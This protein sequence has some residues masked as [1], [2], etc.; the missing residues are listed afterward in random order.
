MNR[1][2]GRIALT[3]KTWQKGTALFLIWVMLFSLFGV[4]APPVSAQEG[5]PASGQEET[6]EPL[7][8][9]LPPLPPLPDVHL[10]DMEW[11][12]AESGWKEVQ[13]NKS[14]EGNTLS[15]GG[16]EYSKGIGTHASS[17]IVY[18]IPAGYARFVSVAGVDNEIN[19]F[20]PDKRASMTFR[21]YADE[22]LLAESP[23]LHANGYWYFDVA[24]PEGAQHLNLIVDDMGSNEFDHADW[25]NAG[26]YN[27]VDTEGDPV[28]I[29][30]PTGAVTASVYFNASGQLVYAVKYSG[31]DVIEES[32]LG[33]YYDNVDLG[34]GVKLGEPERA[35]THNETYPWN[36]G[37][38]QAEDRHNL[39]KIPITH[40]KSGIQYTLEIK[41]FDEGIAFRYVMPGEGTHTISGEKTNFK[42]PAG[43]TVWYQQNT[44]NYEGRFTKSPAESV[45]PST[46]IGPP[47]TI[48]LPEGKGYAAI[49]EGNL[50]DYSGMSLLAAG[51]GVFKANFL[52]DNG[53]W[54]QTGTIE[55]PW[56]IVMMN[57]DL[58]GLV[59]NDIVHNTA[60]APSPELANAD[61]IQPGK[62]TWSWLGGGGVTVEN[63]KQYIDFASQLGI[64]SNLVDE[65]WSHWI[66]GNRDC[67]DLLKEVVDYGTERN[68]KT[69]VWKAAPDRYGIPGIYNREA[70]RE[71]FRKLKE[72]GVVG[73]KID[74]IDGE[75]VNQVNFYRDTLEDAAEYKLMINFHGANKPT[76]LSRTYPHEVSREGIYGLENWNP[77][78]E[79]NTTLPFTRFLAGHA[80]Y[81]PMHFTGRLGDTT[82]SHQLA[83]TITFTS[84]QL[85]FAEHP[86]TI[87]K[88]PAV[89]FIKSIPSVWDETIV[90]P[91]SKIGEVSA[92]ARRQG[93]TWYVAVLNNT[94]AR[95]M[96]VNLSFL[97]E[98]MYQASIYGDKPGEQAAYDMAEKS[99]AKQDRFNV[100]LNAGGGFVAKLS[101]MDMKPYGGGF[102]AKQ[103]VYLTV[104]DPGAE[105]RYTLDGS[106]PTQNSPLYKDFIA[107]DESAVI[108]AKIVAGEGAGSE[109]SARFNKRVPKLAITN[110]GSQSFLH[111]GDKVTLKT[112]NIDAD[113]EIRYTLDGSEPDQ[114]AM[115]YTEPFA[116]YESAIVKAR[117]FVE[118]ADTGVAAERNFTVLDKPRLPDVHLSDLN[119]VSAETEW[120]QVQKN[121]SSDGNSL[122]VGGTTYPKGIG[123]HANSKIVYNIPP[124]ARR[125]VAI[126]GVDDEISESMPGKYASMI[127]KVY[128]DDTLLSESPA[129]HKNDYWYFDVDIPYGSQQLTLIVDDD[130]APE[131]DHADWVQAGF[132]TKVA[133]KVEEITVTG[134]DG[135][136]KIATD[137]GTLQM[138]AS[139]MPQN[140]D[141]KSV[142]WSVSDPGKAS[143]DANGLL[144]AK[145][146][147][148]VDVIA[149]ARDGSG[150][151]GRKTITI[152]GQT[153]AVP[154]KEIVVTGKDQATAITKKG[155]TLQMIASVKPEG[156][157]NKAVTWSVSDPSKAWI[158]ANGLL[159]AKANGRV[160]VRA[161]AQ[162]GS[163]VT[164]KTIITISGQ[165]ISFDADA[166]VLDREISVDLSQEGKADWIR[167]G[168]DKTIKSR[169]NIGQPL[170]QFQPF[171]TQ[172]VHQMYDYKGRFTWNDGNPTA[173]GDNERYGIYM[174]D[175]YSG[176]QITVPPGQHETTVKVY[177]G[178]WAS[179]GRI[180]ALFGDSST[181]VYTDHYDNK[182]ENSIHK[183]YTFR[184]NG[185]ES[186][187]SLII[188][189]KVEG[190]Y[191]PSG[192]V[193]L[194]AAVMSNSVSEN[195]P[196]WPEGSVLTAS[197]IT[198]S[199]AVLTWSGADNSTTKY[200]IYQ[201]N[202]WIGT[203]GSDVKSYK[204][205]ELAAGVTYTFRVEAG[206]ASGDWS[207][208][209]PSASVQT[210]PDHPAEVE[211]IKP[212]EVLTSPGKKPDLPDKV[213]A[214][215]ADGRTEELAVEW[216][217]IDPKRYEKPGTF[218]V[219]GTVAGTDKKATANIFVAY[220]QNQFIVAPA[221]NMDKLEPDRTLQA[222]VIVKNNSSLAEN[223]LVIAALY[224]QDQRMVDLS[225]YSKK[226][227]VG[228]TEKL[229]AGF[230]LPNR[231]QGHQVKVF[232]WRGE[233][234]ENSPMKPLSS[235][236]ILK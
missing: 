177:T 152:S 21:V 24:I 25:V 142:A 65:G 100:K 108:R 43:S 41:A 181:P 81:T 143:I 2:K 224:D 105:V 66:S 132:V 102:A 124:E 64:D 174:A 168:G 121:K 119:W 183:V 75:S 47:L 137:K 178:G 188:K 198:S 163:N 227:D 44:M 138:V 175:L 179:K 19:E 170:L 190:Q 213:T 195:A 207:L 18:H 171:N 204:V 155:G 139:V 203:V 99:V 56:R 111:K 9:E 125:F 197:D 144:T 17:K 80:D 220:E 167:F 96:D 79:H 206:N 58:N 34:Y 45:P 104:A 129:V 122:R 85:V 118:G 154:V 134:K 159:T 151:S 146:D 176:W 219:E 3:K 20:L 42:L 93:T 228:A 199:S 211:A 140:A 62:S 184:F 208:T 141:Y 30:S 223:V 123:T 39:V 51:N 52:Y 98:G 60:P 186:N 87:L 209:G 103:K 7:A 59:N 61:W 194:A 236:V 180:E 50:V 235:E 4:S 216:P 12:S 54:Q 8:L 55:S 94:T 127:F 128:A 187:Q 53:A 201:D 22:T 148:N 110:E 153:G 31:Q 92:F 230:K 49:T 135:A 231:I 101:K 69:W 32:N 48:Q 88:N 113:H 38:A 74:F 13:K 57:A 182:G 35:E 234:I 150:V 106:E 68:V 67:W 23:V 86:E 212:I 1:G 77:W 217:K 226:I 136:A 36:G 63:M 130:G 33:V 5:E 91:G 145:A 202:Q 11:I 76:G 84:P 214:S 70:R 15:V 158:D 160:E 173:A 149:A 210:T 189:G 26:F 28:P 37:H 215:Y 27:L 97:G 166:E 200:K 233:K 205:S 46:R 229:A 162:D 222:S 191:H 185:G 147:G 71:F 73:V 169:K 218:T 83:T 109:V 114:N 165:L 6:A 10:S 116:L 117:L 126:A 164:G 133:L 172:A 115:L 157:T 156:A 16:Q 78:A 232:V 95:D 89:E 14:V 90:L 193:T 196:K 225:S 221:F 72:I 107:L 29:E 40:I 82:W 161:A 131:Y 192:N 112:D 120:G